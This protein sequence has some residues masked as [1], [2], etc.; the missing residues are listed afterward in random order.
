MPT[1]DKGAMPPPRTTL[2]G[3]SRRLRVDASVSQLVDRFAERGATL[4]PN[5]S[6]RS[7]LGGDD[8]RTF[9]HRNGSTITLSTAPGWLRQRSVLKLVTHPHADG[10]LAVDVTRP[11]YTRDVLVTVS[12]V[13]AAALVSSI[14][15]GLWTVPVFALGPL[16]A[17][18]YAAHNARKTKRLERFA[19]EQLAP[20]EL[21][22]GEAGYRQLRAPESD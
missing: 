14:W 13:L 11:S 19:Y 10:G 4:V 9:V 12:F 21:S 22:D 2:V 5:E 6:P 17:A 16:A 7:N 8:P 20:M 18:F 1:L 3:S 15:V